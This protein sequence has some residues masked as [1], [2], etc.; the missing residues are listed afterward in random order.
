MSATYEVGDGT[1]LTIVER[2]EWGAIWAD[3]AGSAPLPATEG[4]AFHHSTDP[5]TSGAQTIRDLENV[6]QSRFRAGISYSFVITPDGRCYEGH[7]IRRKGTH[8]KNHNS[9]IRACCFAGTFMDHLP[10]PAAMETGRRLYHVG[11]RQGWWAPIVTGHRDWKA[12]ACPGDALYPHLDHFTT[13][14]QEEADMTPDQAKQ[15]AQARWAATAAKAEAAAT[16][17]MVSTFYEQLIGS[18]DKA[19]PEALRQLLRETAV[20]ADDAAKQTRPQ[21]AADKAADADLAVSPAPP[22]SPWQT[23]PQAQQD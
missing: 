5:E 22:V 6:G 21:P 14:S 16:R 8:T 15:L 1:E 10:T 7:S 11:V 12:T 2:R 18:K 19:G 13:A 3:G 9:T 4:L 20:D 23:P 17:K